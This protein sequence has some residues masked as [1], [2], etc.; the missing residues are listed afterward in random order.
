[1]V[2][3]PSPY[4][5]AFPYRSSHSLYL[6]TSFVLFRLALR[7]AGG[8][9]GSWVTTATPTLGHGPHRV[10]QSG[11]KTNLVFRLPQRNKFNNIFVFLRFVFYFLFFF[12]SSFNVFFSLVFL[13]LL[14]TN[15]ESIRV[16]TIAQ[17][18]RAPNAMGLF[19]KFTYTY[20]TMW[21]KWV[22]YLLP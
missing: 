21:A 17:R 16:F 22:S 18:R 9:Q 3:S 10:S 15:W 11:R 2:L 14:C 8:G 19:S 6:P 4:H 20:N 7:G 1:M 12:F 13:V 5:D